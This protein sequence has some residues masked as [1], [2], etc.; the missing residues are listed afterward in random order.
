MATE[1]RRLRRPLGGRGRRLLTLATFP[2]VALHEYAHETVCDRYRIPVHEVCYFQ[3]GTPP[4]YVIHARPKRYRHHFA[5]MV[6]PFLLN[7]AVALGLFYAL[8]RGAVEGR[9]PAATLPPTV[10]FVGVVALAWIAVSS[11][12]HAFPSER[13]AT[14]LWL[15]T[16]RRLPWNPLV[17]LGVPVLAVIWL[18]DALRTIWADVAY[19]AG[20]LALAALAVQHQ[21]D[22]A[23][24]VW[25]GL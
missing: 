3:L 6:A 14:E 18:L 2:G 22:V 10:E 8:V 17:L 11:G 16:K 23:I 25:P 12:V 13:D 1:L 7:T 24:L 20:L 4:G 15:Q 5:V 21:L 19:A 9:L